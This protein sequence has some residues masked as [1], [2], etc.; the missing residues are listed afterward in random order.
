MA[1]KECQE[2]EICDQPPPVPSPLE[3]ESERKERCRPHACSKRFWGGE[4]LRSDGL[5]KLMAPESKLRLPSGK[6]PMLVSW[7]RG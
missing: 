5:V 1:L 4:G 2:E 6:T 3:T 7:N